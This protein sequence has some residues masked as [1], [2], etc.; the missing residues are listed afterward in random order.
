[1]RLPLLQARG[2]ALRY[3]TQD[4]I[5]T[6]IEGLD[7][8]LTEGERLMVLGP[9]GCGKSTLL[10]AVAGFVRPEAGEILLRG[11]PVEEPGPDR[12]VVFQE[13]DQL[14]PWKTVLQNVMFPLVASRR[15]TR[16]EAR[17]LALHYL[18]RVG[19]GDFIDAYP[20]T[21]S[22]GMK[23][24][25][26]LARALAVAP[27]MLLMDEPFASLDALT[28]RRMQQ[29]LLQLWEQERFTM[30]FVTHSVAEAVALGTRILLLSPHP[31]R[32]L[33]ELDGVPAGP[34]AQRL[35]AEIEG[36]L[37]ILPEAA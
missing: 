6:A 22:G 27:A 36:L 13:F 20:H 7:F 34:E 35:Q 2:L 19:L 9:S 37:H 30:L 29:E 15:T 23:Q 24:R 10:K 3:R 28:R 5:V 16:A 11:R 31:G 1:M 25:V 32:R 4:R 18:Q 21:L 33:A 12:M 14:P 26:A 8:E 17:G